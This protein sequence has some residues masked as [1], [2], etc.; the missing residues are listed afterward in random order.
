MC[1]YVPA[2]GLVASL[3]LLSV[4]SLS[5]SVLLLPARP[6]AVPLGVT[7]FLVLAVT[8][9]LLVAAGAETTAFTFLSY[10]CKRTQTVLRMTVI[11]QS[12]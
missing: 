7:T 3:L 5:V 8:E 11:K 10:V 4:P 6:L 12:V 2:R 1:A 9:S